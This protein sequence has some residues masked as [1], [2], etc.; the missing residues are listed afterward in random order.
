MAD[1]SRINDRMLDDMKT[2]D[3]ARDA[4]SADRVQNQSSADAK[5]KTTVSSMAAQAAQL[6]GSRRGYS[7]GSPVAS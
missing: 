1:I 7:N 3:A 5:E 4:V 2:R 6:V